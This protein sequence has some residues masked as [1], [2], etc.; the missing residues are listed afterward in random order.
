[1]NAIP[2][3]PLIGV[4]QCPHDGACPLFNPGASR[5]VCGFSQRLQRPSFVRL[6]KHSGVG[7][8]DSRYSYVVIRRGP[9][10]K[11][12]AEVGQVGRIGAVAK[13]VLEKEA[14]RLSMKEL[15]LSEDHVEQADA[16][17]DV[18]INVHGIAELAHSA[19]EVQ[20]ALRLEAFSWPR[21]VFPPM[22]KSGHVILDSCTAEGTELLPTICEG[23]YY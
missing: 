11:S 18:D 21:L 9:R 5:I 3:V 4:P 8:E 17:D 10:P 7:H 14:E 1:M 15:V 23:A 2:T 20:E 16:K 22:K 19:D 13:S 12:L 6:T